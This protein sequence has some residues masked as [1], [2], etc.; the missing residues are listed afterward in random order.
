MNPLLLESQ[1]QRT[2]SPPDWFRSAIS[3]SLRFI[4]EKAWS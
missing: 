2:Q 4:S 3:I 1:D